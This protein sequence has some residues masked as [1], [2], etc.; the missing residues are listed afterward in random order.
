LLFFFLFIFFL[1][2]CFILSYLSN[3]FFFFFLS[4]GANCEKWIHDTKQ[5]V[6]D[7]NSASQN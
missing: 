4:G 7:L 1:D 2:I 3:R 6:T 5:L